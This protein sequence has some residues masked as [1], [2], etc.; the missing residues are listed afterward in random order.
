MPDGPGRFKQ[1]FTCP[2]LLRSHWKEDCIFTYAAVTLYGRPFQTV[3]LTLSYPSFNQLIPSLPKRPVD[4]CGPATPVSPF[5]STGLGFSDFARHYFRNHGCFLF[6]R[7]LRWFTSPSLLRHPMNSDDG[8]ECSHSLGYPIRKSPDHNLLAASRSLSQLITSFFAFLRQG[9]H[10]HALSSLTIKSTSH[11][12]LCARY[13]LCAY[14]CRQSAHL[15]RSCPLADY[16]GCRYICPSI[17]NCQRSVSG[18]I[19]KLT[20]ETAGCTHGNFL[21]IPGFSLCILCLVGLGRIELPTSPLS[22]VRSSQLS[23]RPKW[24]ILVELVGIEPATS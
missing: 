8:N 18:R 11:T 12:T 15:F 10:T 2:A 4:Y 24:S 1:G 23:Y 5:E 6:L 3:R 13:V 9:I 17:F 22:G 7:V 19:Q 21:R 16:T 14:L 20:P